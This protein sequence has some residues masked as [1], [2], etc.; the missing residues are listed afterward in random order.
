MSTYD[1]AHI[2]KRKQIVQKLQIL[3]KALER[4]KT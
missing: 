4:A 1:M 2:L 3:K